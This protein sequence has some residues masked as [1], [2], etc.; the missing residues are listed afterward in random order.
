MEK[1]NLS[2]FYQLGAPLNP[3]TKFV[4]DV[5]NRISIWVASFPAHSYTYTLFTEFKTL[6]ACR[7]A[8][9]ERINSIFKMQQW[10]DKRSPYKWQE[11]N[12]SV[13]TI[14]SNVI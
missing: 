8:G 3:L 10:L 9:V 2:F 6:I 11:E 1:I 7:N 12:R 5:D 14:F 13:D 4:A